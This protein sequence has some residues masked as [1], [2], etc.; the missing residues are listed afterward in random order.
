MIEVHEPARLLIVIEQTTAILDVAFAKL[1][2][3]LMEWLD[4]NWVRLVACHPET[5]QLFFYHHSGWEAVE[6]PG[7]YVAPVADCAETIFTGKHRTIPVHVI[8]KAVATA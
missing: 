3:T 6:L 8:T 2:D 5:R 4:N 7:D 1:G